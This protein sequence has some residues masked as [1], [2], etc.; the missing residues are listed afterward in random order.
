MAKYRAPQ[1]AKRKLQLSGMDE[2][3]ATY[4]DVFLVVTESETSMSSITFFQSQLSLQSTDFGTTHLG[5]R[6]KAKCVAQIV[7]S[8]KAMDKLLQAIVDNRAA[9]PLPSEEQE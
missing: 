8:D 9:L 7:L 6:T 2:I 4:A 5:G 3:T 1:P